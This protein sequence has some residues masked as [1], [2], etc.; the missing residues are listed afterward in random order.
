MHR[1]VRPRTLKAM[2]AVG[3][4]AA[5]GIAIPA[6]N[7]TEEPT[8]SATSAAPTAVPAHALTGYWQNFDNGATVQNSRDV[9]APVR[10]HRGLVR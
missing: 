6:A 1:K 7:A 9:Q 8:P 2:L 10:H 5:A 4:L 3:V